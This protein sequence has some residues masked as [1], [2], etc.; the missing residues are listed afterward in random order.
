M[1]EWPRWS[2]NVHSLQMAWLHMSQYSRRTS[3]GWTSQY[4]NDGDEKSDRPPVELQPPAEPEPDPE[5]DPEPEPEPE[6]SPFE[7]PL[8][9]TWT[10]VSGAPTALDEDDVG[11]SSAKRTM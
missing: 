3:A 2:R 9:L 4:E 11:G 1:N 7:P 8:P 5:P 6:P 10:L